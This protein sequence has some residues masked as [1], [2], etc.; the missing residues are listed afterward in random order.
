MLH[1]GSWCVGSF[2]LCKCCPSAYATPT[3]ISHVP[4]LYHSLQPTPTTPQVSPLA[5]WL[6]QAT[7]WDR[8]RLQPT[9]ANRFHLRPFVVVVEG[10]TFSFETTPFCDFPP[11]F[12]H[13]KDLIRC[14]EASLWGKVVTEKKFFHVGV[15]ASRTTGRGGL[16][17]FQSN[18]AVGCRNDTTSH[19]TA[20]Y[21]GRG[22]LQGGLLCG[23]LHRRRSMWTTVYRS[24]LLLGHKP[25]KN[26]AATGYAR[27]VGGHNEYR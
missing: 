22:R 9:A 17:F 4:P 15:R 26:V 27:G 16:A 13:D 11:I 18:R 19:V 23:R 6:P 5:A 10:S 1:L 7:P 3:C 25:C 8:P 14:R 12:N 20:L 21:C 2:F 24:P